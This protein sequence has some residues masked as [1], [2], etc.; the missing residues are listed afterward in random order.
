MSHVQAYRQLLRELKSS[1]SGKLNR[2]ILTTFRPLF[3][4]ARA[5]EG[6]EQKRF[7]YD[8]ENTLTFLKA[9]RE[10]KALLDRYNPLVDLT[11][12][13]RIEATAR[14]VGL[15]MPK[16]RQRRPVKAA[17][18]KKTRFGMRAG[19]ILRSRA[20]ALNTAA[21]HLTITRKPVAFPTETVY[22]LGALAL[23]AA[24]AKQIFQVK[25]RPADNPLISLLPPSFVFS[26]TYEILM[27]R[28]WPGPLTLLF[29]ASP[30]VVPPLVTAKHPTV[31]VRQPAHP[32]AR[33]L[34]ALANA[35]LA[36]PSANSSGKPSPT[37][38]EHVLHDLDGKISYILDGGACDVG[39]ESTVIDGLHE[40]GHI[41]VLRPGGV[42][43]EDLEKAFI[44]MID[45]PEQ[46]PRV[47]VHRR[48]YND[49]QMEAAPTTP[50]MKY[51][52]Y[53]PTVPVEL[54][55]TLSSPSSSPHPRITGQQYL[56][57]LQER[58]RSLG[59]KPKLGILAP[60]DGILAHSDL[61]SSS[62]FISLGAIPPSW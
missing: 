7:E 51:T 21:Q 13:E 59:R 61:H 19:F 24:A 11:A 45:I 14:R 46:R 15:N 41:R 23:D 42:T 39:V 28:F 53:S 47:L 58:F 48:D 38:A 49:K 30:D 44:D 27:T 16:G 22:G 35:P 10:Y 33:A 18:E 5:T 17:K 6:S 8:I 25:G 54:V 31:A 1:A 9:Q 2:H 50:G 55:M 20:Y 12:E 26:R 32:V 3:E 60:S 57:S 40:D 29:P 62:H 56:D 37:K 52:H 36:A 4:N 43:V 34:I